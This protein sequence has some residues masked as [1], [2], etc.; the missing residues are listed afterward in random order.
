M[1]PFRIENLEN[2]SLPGKKG[3]ETSL[4]RFTGKIGLNFAGKAHDPGNLKENS[5]EEMTII[6]S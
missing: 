5:S 1:E 4:K 3:Q 2:F 6:F